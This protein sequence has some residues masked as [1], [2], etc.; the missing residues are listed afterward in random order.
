M[1]LS[2]EP[3]TEDRATLLAIAKDN[4]ACQVCNGSGWTGENIQRTCPNCDGSGKERTTLEQR[5]EASIKLAK[6]NAL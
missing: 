3:K 2:A 5:I 4:L 6:Y 1:T